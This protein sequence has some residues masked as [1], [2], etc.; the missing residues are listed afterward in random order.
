MKKFAEKHDLVK[1]AGIMVLITVLLTWVIPQGYYSGS[2]ISVGD[3]TRVGLF[4]FFT[5]GLLGMYYFTVLVTFVFVLGAFYQVLSKTKGYQDLTTGIAKI[6]KGKEIIFVL[7]VSFVIAAISAITNEYIVILSI[8][9]FIITIMKK[10]KL[11]KIT[12]FATTFGAI[13]VGTIGSIY[14]TKIVGMNVS[15][16]STEYGTLLWAKLVMFFLAYIAF[17]VFTVLHMLKMRKNKK[18]A[19]MED[20][21]ECEKSNENSR[22]KAWTVGLV[23][24]LFA[25]ITLLAYLPWT[26]VFNTEWAT[27]AL[28]AINNCEV[29]GSTI[30]A[31]I[32]GS[33]YAFGE[34]DI[35]GVQVLMLVAILIIKIIDKIPFNDIITSFGEGFKKVG[36]LVVIMLLC[37]LILEFAVMY[38][39]LPTIVDW[40]LNLSWIAKASDKVVVILS[41]LTGLLTSMFTVEYQYTLSLIGQYLVGTYETF[42]NQI[43]FMLQTT[44]GLASM[45]TPA[46]AILLMGLSYL[47][48]TYKEWMKYIW[49]FLIIMFVIIIILM[50]IIC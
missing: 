33:V 36:K 29:F 14:S 16:L 9:P 42:T 7:V 47:G 8:V 4:D 20:L 17:N 49:K 22:I 12:G 31:Y 18:S 30:F 2:A 39:V 19:V 50:I 25:I 35:F 6:F 5:Y 44:F 21:F 45:F 3:I 11:D 27:N 15:Y 41:T 26:D 43:A 46:S 34:W 28:D 13:L 23:L 32:L 37:Y 24:G 38:P 48:I 40:F 1:A 10:M